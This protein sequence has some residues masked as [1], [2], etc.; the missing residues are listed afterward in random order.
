[1]VPPEKTI[2]EAKFPKHRSGFSS[3]PVFADGKLYC[4]R[5]DA[6]T[7]VVDVSDQIEIVSEN[8]VEGQTVATPVL[9]SG[10]VFLRTYDEIICI[11]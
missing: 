10:K 8:K 1:M 4:T 6:T 2:S 3:S 5:E 7:F 11:K 9:H